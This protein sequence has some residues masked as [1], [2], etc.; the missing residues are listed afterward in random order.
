MAGAWESERT[1]L[2]GR[3]RAA[4]DHMGMP[5]GIPDDELEAI[6][7]KREGELTP[8]SAQAV[9]DQMTILA[10]AHTEKGHATVCARDACGGKATR[11]SP[12]DKAWVCD[13][14]HHYEQRTKKQ[15]TEDQIVRANYRR[16]QSGQAT[17]ASA[18]WLHR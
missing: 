3:I 8:R 15:R 14:D 11:R 16:M 18:G 1:K 13:T 6:V 12:I 2:L 4:C 5:L 9:I 17:R 10:K 7:V